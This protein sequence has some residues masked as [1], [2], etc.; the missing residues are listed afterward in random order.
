MSLLSEQQ[1]NAA[2]EGGLLGQ[3]LKL[4]FMSRLEK[5]PTRVMVHKPPRSEENEITEL[6][7]MCQNFTV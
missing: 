7:S 4:R 1:V 2:A 3:E 6:K 5:K